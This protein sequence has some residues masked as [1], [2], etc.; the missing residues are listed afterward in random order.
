MSH[1]GEYTRPSVTSSGCAYATLDNYNQNYYAL[2]GQGAP[3]PAQAMSNQIIVVPS[4][5]GPGYN[6][7]QQRVPSCSG[8][9]SIQSAYGSSN[10]CGVFASNLRN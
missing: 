6:L 5:G 2:G 1:N 10:Q 4:Y 7:T 8:Y 9:S 3:V